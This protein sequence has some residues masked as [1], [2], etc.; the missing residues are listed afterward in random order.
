MFRSVAEDIARLVKKYNGSLSGEHGDGRLRGEF[1]P[2]M[3]GA[4]CYEFMRR[5]RLSSIPRHSQSRQDHRHATDGYLA[6]PLAG[7]SDTGVRDRF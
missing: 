1:I 6:P 7:A 4:E 3:V 2:L 5:P